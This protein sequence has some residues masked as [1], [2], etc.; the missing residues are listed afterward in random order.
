VYKV[1]GGGDGGRGKLCG[2]VPRQIGFS[3]IPGGQQRTGNHEGVPTLSKSVVPPPPHHQVVLTSDLS[4]FSGP[5]T[6]TFLLGDFALSCI[7]RGTSKFYSLWSCT[8]IGY[9]G[10]RSVSEW[11]RYMFKVSDTFSYT[12]VSVSNILMYSLCFEMLYIVSVAIIFFMCGLSV[13]ETFLIL[14]T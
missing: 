1:R 2:L 14:C 7:K 13:Y 10:V 4:T 3:P 9:V 11:F 8:D 6:R 12:Y 5:T